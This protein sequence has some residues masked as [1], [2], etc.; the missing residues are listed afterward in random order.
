MITPPVAAARAGAKAVATIDAS[1]VP[2]LLT[3]ND[4]ELQ[5]GEADVKRSMQK[6]LET[7]DPANSFELKVGTRI[8]VNA[9]CRRLSIPSL[10]LPV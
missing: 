2:G 5:R 1:P 7:F 3:A 10:T 4:A 6:L 9:R 8:M